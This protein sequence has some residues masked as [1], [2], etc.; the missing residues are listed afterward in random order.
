[1]SLGDSELLKFREPK[2]NVK[3]TTGNNCCTRIVSNYSTLVG[4][5][6]YDYP[7]RGQGLMGN[8]SPAVASNSYRIVSNLSLLLQK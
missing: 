4:R 7:L 8:P 5:L 6:G 3:I 1:M 2:M